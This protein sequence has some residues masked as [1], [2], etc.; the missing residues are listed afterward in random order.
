M[1][2]K[3][4]LILAAAALMLPTRSLATVDY[5]V[6]N[7]ITRQCTYLNDDM[8]YQPIAWKGVGEKNSDNLRAYCQ[9]LGYSYTDFPYIIESTICISAILILG[10]TWF[11]VFKKKRASF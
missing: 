6:V 4:I 7:H 1:N 10:L 9:S 11:L 2:F 8:L 3:I 5:G